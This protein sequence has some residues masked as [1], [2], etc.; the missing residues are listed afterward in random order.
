MTHITCRLTAKNRDQLR[1]PT[2]GNRVRATFSFL[3]LP[4][5]PVLGLLDAQLCWWVARR[6]AV[7]IC[8]WSLA[9]FSCPLSSSRTLSSSAWSS[10]SS[11]VHIATFRRITTHKR[12]FKPRSDKFRQQRI[13]EVDFTADLTGTGNRPRVINNHKVIF[14]VYDTVVDN[15]D[16]DFPCGRLS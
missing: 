13:V 16:A 8:R 10:C 11:S 6:S 7:A 1:N 4:L 5:L 12:A 9:L 14:F 3:L 2:L 15:N